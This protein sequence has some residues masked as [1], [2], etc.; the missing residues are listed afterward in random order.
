MSV[1]RIVLG[2][3]LVMALSMPLVAQQQKTTSYY[4]V[5]CVKVNQGQGV[6]F[7][8]FFN[9]T[10]Y[11][12]EQELAN[13]GRVQSGL[14]LQTVLPQGTEAK[15]D[16]VFVTFSNGL[17]PEQ[18]STE[19]M[20]TALHN[21]GIKMTPEEY[22]TQRGEVATLV[23]SNISQSVAMVGEAKK[24]DYLV[25]NQ[26]DAPDIGACLALEKKVWQPLAEEMV[27]AGD[28]DG[29]ATQVQIFPWGA[30][31]EAGVSSVDIYPSWN[32]VFKQRESI[33]N[34]W[35]K[36]HPDMD[37]SSTLDQFE[38]VC[39]IEHTVLYKV[40]GLVAPKK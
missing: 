15:C 8:E 28:S 36:V 38:K 6:A 10:G 1:P 20:S 34:G 14:M 3:A 12:L 7:H 31:D 19:E 39:P 33:G 40:V 30:K 22:Y 13:S 35:K 27:K 25:L 17:P 2:A 4:E 21:A 11:K 24:G 16:Y 26:M 37:I 32:A 5:A 29:W 23:N 18:L 9:G